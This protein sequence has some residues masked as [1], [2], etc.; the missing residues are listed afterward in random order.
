VKLLSARQ[1]V[2][3]ETATTRRCRCRCG[4]KLHGAGRFTD[5][6]DAG[7]LRELPAGDPHAIPGQLM[8][9]FDPRGQTD[10]TTPPRHD[11]TGASRAGPERV[12]A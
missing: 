12:P 9:P 7:A 5:P 11:S 1:A 8:L 6:D 10:A 4:G 3:C 2:S